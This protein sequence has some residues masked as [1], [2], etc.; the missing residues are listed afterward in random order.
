MFITC[1]AT[2]HHFHFSCLSKHTDECFHRGWKA[3]TPKKQV[4]ESTRPKNMCLE[5]KGEKLAIRSALFA[6]A[7]GSWEDVPAPH[8]SCLF[9]LEDKSNSN[10]HASIC[11]AVNPCHFHLCRFATSPAQVQQL[12]SLLPHTLI[13][14]IIS[15]T[16]TG[17]LILNVN[18]ILFSPNA[19]NQTDCM[20]LHNWNKQSF[21]HEKGKTAFGEA[22]G[23]QLKESTYCK[24]PKLTFLLTD[25]SITWRNEE[26]V[27]LL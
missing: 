11:F 9:G 24:N 12:S 19:I 23:P 16:A 10:C 18:L 7:A 1:V 14:A 21:L 22:G 20:Q 26:L 6:H 4:L 8:I 2:R 3:H 27:F 13:P 15:L 17:F 5:K 25:Q